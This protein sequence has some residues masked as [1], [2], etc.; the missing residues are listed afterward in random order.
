MIRKIEHG[1]R[2]PRVEFLDRADDVLNAGGHLRAF[3]E[4][5]EKAR[6]PKKARELKEL[7]DRAV[8]VL[9]YSNHNIQ[10]LLQTP[11]YARALFQVAQPAYSPD[12]VERGIAA[13]TARKSIFERSLPR[14]SVSSRSR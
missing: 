14:R 11:E 3:R 5:V 13:R 6:Y 12:E 10:G 4:D 8:E 7:E 1:V 9:L 2:I